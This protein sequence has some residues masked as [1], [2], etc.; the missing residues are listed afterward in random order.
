VKRGEIQLKL[1]KCYPVAFQALT[2]Q[3]GI[4][5]KKLLI[6]TLAIILSWS[7]QLAADTP[8][9][10]RAAL[11]YYAEMWNEGDFDALASYYHQDFVLVTD[12]GAIPG[13]QRVSDLKLLAE[14]GDTGRM[15]HDSLVVK[16]LGEG[17]AM[18][19]GQF[20]LSFEDGSKISTWFT[21]I[22]VKT[23]FGWKAMLA[24]N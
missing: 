6:P 21:T 10:I 20:T 4:P 14:T 24:H 18:A 15:K 7:P 3:V 23:P 8:G 11:D 2:I 1:P 13:R 16:E 12:K 19:Y 5:L 22:Y 17:N 9:D